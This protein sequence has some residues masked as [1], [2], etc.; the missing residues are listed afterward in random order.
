MPL[1][2]DFSSSILSAPLDVSR[3]GVIYAGA[4]KNIGPSGLCVVIVRDDLLER[5]RAV[6][7]SIWNWRQ[8]AADGS[9]SNTPPT[10][11]W[12]VAGLVFQW[13]KAQ[14]GLARMGK[15]NRRKAEALYAADRRQRLLSQ[16]RLRPRTAPS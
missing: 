9:M 15:R 13:L 1:V 2:A 14:G 7:P 11:G 5:A 3:F 8:M 16:S 4:Q 10:F 6:T 12:Y